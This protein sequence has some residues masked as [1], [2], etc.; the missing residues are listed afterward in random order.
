MGA[1]AG[2]RR[3]RAHKNDK[4]IKKKYR[5]KRR[6]KDL[7]EVLEDMQ[8]SLPRRHT[9]DVP[10][11]GQ[12]YCLMCSRTF[13][14]GKAVKSHRNSKPHKQRLRSLMEPAYTQREAE[15]AAG[16]GSYYSCRQGEKH[17]T[18]TQTQSQ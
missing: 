2:G 8:K 6:T 1:G 4:H 7:D 10:G 12:H 5:T 14:D 15:C 11:S 13:M 17:M 16:K 18:H 9:A 3:K